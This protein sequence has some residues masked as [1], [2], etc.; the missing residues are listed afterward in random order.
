MKQL[1]IRHTSVLGLLA[2]IA[3]MLLVGLAEAQGIP[4]FNA[5][6]EGSQGTRYTLSM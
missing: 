3:L 1:F 5:L 4:A 2:G 6:N